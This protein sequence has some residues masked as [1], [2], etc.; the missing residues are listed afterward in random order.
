MTNF[1]KPFIR[2]LH[3]TYYELIQ[4]SIFRSKYAHQSMP[5]NILNDHQ[6]NFLIFKFASHINFC[7]PV[8]QTLKDLGSQ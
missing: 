7:F 6:M 4:F 2:K 1:S 8:F 5:I 3:Y